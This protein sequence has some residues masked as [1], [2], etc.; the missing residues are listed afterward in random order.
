MS[1]RSPEFRNFELYTLPLSFSSQKH[2]RTNFCPISIIDPFWVIWGYFRRIVTSQSV[3]KVFVIL[4]ITTMFVITKAYPY[5]YARH[6]TC[7]HLLGVVGAFWIILGYFREIVKSQC[8][9]RFG[10]HRVSQHKEHTLMAWI[11]GASVLWA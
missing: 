4:Y 2:I 1:G 10:R 3:K 9:R 6:V 8:V 7:W 5:H 11:H